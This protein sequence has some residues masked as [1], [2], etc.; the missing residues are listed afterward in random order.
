[1]RTSNYISFLESLQK[2]LSKIQDQTPCMIIVYGPCEY[3]AFKA[4]KAVRTV[5]QN[6]TMAPATTWD[7]EE[8]KTTNL[9]E[10]FE[11]RNLFEPTSL[12]MIRRIKKTADYVRAL[13][14]MPAKVQNFVVL[15]FE[16]DKLTTKLSDLIKKSNA[17]IIPC[18]E[19]SDE[20]F[21]NISSHLL[22]KR[23]LNL[24]TDS[25]RVLLKNSSHNL[26]ALENEIDRLS[27]IF[28]DE[29]VV[30][31]AELIPHLNTIPEEQSFKMISMLLE[32]KNVQTKIFIE[33]LLQ[34]GESPIAI[35]SLMAWHCRNALKVHASLN[36]NAKHEGKAASPIK[37]SYT[38][39][40]A[41]QQY[42]RN[43]PVQQIMHA[44]TECQKSDAALKSSAANPNLVL[45][46][47]LNI[48]LKN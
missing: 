47:A 31:P 48:L 41:Y 35:N 33:S 7:G 8:F 30:S 10:L 25:L 45:S 1:M 5:W 36:K 13:S 6:K 44:L 38:M 43:V 24:S 2:A 14:T 9:N 12:H 37:L 28:T 22:K 17:L 20:D 46:L 29:Q 4:L 26:Y 3:F 15:F 23:K 39:L 40:K 27:L 32:R 18:L 11:Q 21:P 42:V 19:P 16:I 34:Q